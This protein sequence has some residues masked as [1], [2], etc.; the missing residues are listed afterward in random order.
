[1]L[2]IVESLLPKVMEVLHDN[3]LFALLKIILPPAYHR[4]SHPCLKELP[5]C[6]EHL[7]SIWVLQLSLFSIQVVHVQHHI[8]ALNKNSHVTAG[9]GG[10]AYQTH[11]TCR[12]VR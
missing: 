8:T 1:M 5:N 9:G 12:M 2:C 10:G 3:L 6:D 11:K 7:S 4:I